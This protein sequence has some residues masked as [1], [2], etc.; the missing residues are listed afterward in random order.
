M[1]LLLPLLVVLAGWRRG[2]IDSRQEEEV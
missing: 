2:Q 1:M